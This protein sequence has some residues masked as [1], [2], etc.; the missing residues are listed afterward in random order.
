MSNRLLLLLF[1]TIIFYSPTGFS[2]DDPNRKTSSFEV[3]KTDNLND[4]IFPGHIGKFPNDFVELGTPSDTFIVVDVGP[5]N[6]IYATRNDEGTPELTFDFDIYRYVG[7]IAKLKKHGLISET[8]KLH[9]PAFDIDTKSPPRDCDGDEINDQIAPE[10]DEVY[11]NGEKIGVLRGSNEKWDLGRNT[12]ELSIDK[13]NLLTEPTAGGFARNTLE[14]EVDVA[15]KDTVLSSG[16]IGCK[17][18]ATEIDFVILEFEVVDPIALNVGLFG[19]PSTFE[20]SGFKDRI[21]EEYGIPA[22]IIDHGIAVLYSSCNVE[23]VDQLS[24]YKHAENVLERLKSAAI[25]YGAHRFNLVVHS[26]AGLDAKSLVNILNAEKPLVTVGKMQTL[27]VE[28]P[29]EINSIATLDTPFKGSSVADVMSSV[30]MFGLN[31]VTGFIPD[32]C[33][34]QTE[35]STLFSRIYPLSSGSID[36]KLLTLGG[37]ADNT[38]NWDLL[39]DDRESELFPGGKY[40]HNHLFK[41]VRDIEYISEEE[42]TVETFFG[43]YTFK[44]PRRKLTSE[45][46]PNDGVVSLESSQIPESDKHIN[47]ISNHI[48]IA[49]KQEPLDD[50]KS[51]GQDIVLEEALNG[52]LEWRVIQ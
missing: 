11:F 1:L 44:F 25:D 30:D 8:F 5:G 9:I 47:T 52:V 2:L 40:I 37:N 14:I 12:F 26:K 16:Q 35:V 28:N 46:Q 38:G 50:I 22:F 27:D 10:V 20:A 7:D 15:N 45:Y 29:I 24:Y 13:L 3:Q 49:Y 34:L 51:G 19:S 18:W 41:I 6:D 39:D 43:T 4:S 17:A 42:Q 31:F 33:D 48:S 32:I 23:Q 36:I 21:M